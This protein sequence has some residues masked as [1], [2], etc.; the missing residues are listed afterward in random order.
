VSLQKAVSSFSLR[1]GSVPTPTSLPALE[2]SL[3]RLGLVDEK[4]LEHAHS[5]GDQNDLGTILVS[6]GALSEEQL[7]QAYC[8]MSGLPLWDG[9]GED[10]MDERFD[11]EFLAFNHV[12]PVQKEAERW[13]IIDDGEDDGFVDLL[14]RTAPDCR[15]ALYPTTE[16]IHRLQK[17]EQTQTSQNVSL[18]ND[19]QNDSEL[20]AEQLKD[21][22][23]EAPII[24]L[25]TDIINN[26]VRIDAS[27]IHLEPFRNHIDLR[28]RVDG[29]LINRPAPSIEDY[30]AVV[31]RVKILADL[32][33]AERRLP[34]DGRIRTRSSGRDI[35]IRVSTMPSPFGED[36]VLRLL[37]KKQHRLSL[38]AIELSE[39][40]LTP[41]RESL[42]K[43]NGIILV[44]G[45][46]GSGKTTTLYAALQQL[47]DGSRKIITV[48]D[49][50]EYEISGITQTPVDESI[51]MSFS[52]A[53]RSILRH[54]PD[55]IF[56]G[57]IRDRETADIAIQSALT[58]HL[59]LST[60]HTNNAIG[61]I[62]RFLDMGTPDY[63]LASS[64]VAV[65]AQRLV[66][67]L[68]THCKAPAQIPA[69]FAERF[70]I[71]PETQVYQAV[72]CHK[73]SHTGY[74]GRTPIAEF[75]EITSDVRTAIVQDPNYD[76]LNAAA[77]RNYPK[78]LLDDGIDK[79]ISGTTTFE[80]VIRIVG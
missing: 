65:T 40:V 79:V 26:A 23:L 42:N 44:T 51:G 32:D 47:I 14:N 3:L 74:H 76:S 69:H 58:G 59:V 22:A 35:D 67:R 46:T 1:D 49:P 48:E 66:R 41:F 55:I 61:A 64:L 52:T 70:Q 38:D 30:P 31:S 13:L 50:I 18:E 36:I 62:T 25:V 54:D 57:E 16:L 7:Y 9:D 19:S 71:P 34:Q 17:H 4:I 12:L 43:H 5:V 39:S 6:M 2:E 78:T 53:L 73:C 56:I 75:K 68:C 11:G 10:V 77:D 60:L 33:I 8:D 27:D 37:D 80:E 21:L 15:I 28:Y 24:R 29:S 72:G 45:P 63:L 20:L